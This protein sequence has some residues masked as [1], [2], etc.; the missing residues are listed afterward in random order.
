MKTLLSRNNIQNDFFY[1]FYRTE[2]RNKIVP[3]LVD[4][5]GA[6][7]RASCNSKSSFSSAVFE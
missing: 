6:T 5:Q 1:M 2:C 4:A 3:H 7:Y